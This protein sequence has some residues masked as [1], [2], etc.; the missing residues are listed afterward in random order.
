[1]W[2]KKYMPESLE[3]VVGQHKAVSRLKR[4]LE[5]WSEDKAAL[6]YGPPGSGKT[7]S[8]YA[9]AKEK[10]LD[11]VELNASDYRNEKNIEEVIGKSS[12]QTSLF[13]RGKI[14][15]LDEIDGLS[16]NKDRGGIAALIKI[17]K[18]SRFPII[19]TANDP[20]DPKLRSLRKHSVMINFG[21]IH[22]NSVAKRLREVSEQEGID[23]DH[24]VLKQIARQSNGDL[25]AA[26]NDLEALGLGKEKI[27]KDD[28]DILES[29]DIEQS[30]FEFLKII[31]KSKKLGPAHEVL[32]DVDKDPD[33]IFWWIEENVKR[34]YEKPQEISKAFKYL[35]KAESFR[36][37]IYKKQNWALKKYMIDFMCAVALAKEE[38]YRKFTSYRPPKRLMMYGRSKSMRKKRDE[39]YGKI[40]KKL[41]C[42]KKDVGR[43]MPYFKL[44]IKKSKWKNDFVNEFNLSEGELD[45]IKKG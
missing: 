33:E 36:S 21:K 24:R 2:T 7:V 15:L 4:W 35:G 27:E 26:L 13:R 37:R 23:A 8:I 6:I 44:M 42:S 14:I 41:H 5:N 20:Y 32:R 1:M 31:F 29:R 12:Q 17:I 45:M 43:M 39:L 9:L 10:K 19:M 40:S 16:G 38:M 22:M 3:N 11:L 25:R 28:L 30:I 34:E 18:K